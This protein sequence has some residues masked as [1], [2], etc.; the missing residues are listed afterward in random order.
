LPN[1]TESLNEWNEHATKVKWKKLQ[2]DYSKYQK[3]QEVQQQ[4]KYSIAIQNTKRNM[5]AKCGRE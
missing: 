3:R 4:K 5:S 1:K 2:N